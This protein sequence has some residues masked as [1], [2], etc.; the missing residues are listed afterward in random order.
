MALIG[1]LVCTDKADN[2]LTLTNALMVAQALPPEIR[3]KWGD[4]SS[5]LTYARLHRLFARTVQMFEGGNVGGEVSEMDDLFNAFLQAQLDATGIDFGTVEAADGT[6]IRS[7]ARER[8]RDPSD[9][10]KKWNKENGRDRNSKIPYTADPDAVTGHYPSKG[11]QS[12]FANGFEVHLTVPVPEGSKAMPVVA[13]AMTVQPNSTANRTALRSL[14]INRRHLI[15]TLIVDAG[16]DRAGPESFQK[17]FEFGIAPIF[18]PNKSMRHG[19]TRAHGAVIVDGDL[20]CPNTPQMLIELPDFAKNMTQ[21]E[22]SSL[23]ALY[24]ERD[25]YRFE[26]VSYGPDKIRSMCPAQAKKVKCTGVPVSL[27]ISRTDLP[28][29]EA[30]EDRPKC[31]AQKTITTKTEEL[32]RSRQGRYAYGTSKWLKLYGQRNRTESYN[33]DFRHNIGSFEER[34]WCAVMGRVKM[35]FMLGIKLLA[36][37]M[38][39]IANFVADSS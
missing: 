3:S 14:A 35:T 19:K 15:D 5:E 4:R 16:Y 17:L 1:Y 22:R 27:N 28:Y 36:T 21:I 6:V 26:R 32:R 39:K 30:P 2:R 18:D 7:T 9:A 25:R 23:Q 20:F 11:G 10:D 29:V 31:C 38:T 12:K 34:K 33:A 24:D 8:F 13:S 37:N